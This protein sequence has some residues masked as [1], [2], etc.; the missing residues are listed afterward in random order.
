MTR[1]MLA[2]AVAAIAAVAMVVPA[3]A[4]DTIKQE[5]KSNW[6]ALSAQ[7][8]VLLRK[9]FIRVGTFKKCNIEAAMLTDLSSSRDIK[10]IRF[11]YEVTK[12]YTTGTKVAFLDVDELDALLRSIALII[13][14]IL[15]SAPENYVEVAFTSRGGFAAG[16][17]YTSGKWTGF[18]KLERFDGDS[19][20]WFD[21]STYG[22]L[23]A[24]LQQVKTKL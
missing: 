17:Y 23:L 14:E 4:Q 15:P 22:E 10:G 20:I 18:M 19:F 7:D 1:H 5:Q 3:T 13:E 24:I 6:E 12:Q 2:V 16:C 8:G 9:E 11:S 21:S